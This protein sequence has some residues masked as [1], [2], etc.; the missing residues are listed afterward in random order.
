MVNFLE[1]LLALL[2][3]IGKNQF[4]AMYSVMYAL[5]DFKTLSMSWT[6]RLSR[7]FGSKAIFLVGVVASVYAVA[8]LVTNNL[9]PDAPKPCHDVILKSRF[10]SPKPSK[11]IVILDIDERSL[12]MLSA[13]YGR[14]PW[15]RSV[16][17]DG[18]QKVSDSGARAVMLNVMLSDPDKANA[19]ADAVMD[20]TAQMVRPVAFPLIRL[21]ASNDAVSQ[22]K[23]NQFSGSEVSSAAKPQ[24]TLAVI[25]PF[26]NSMHDRLGIANQKPDEDGIIRK[27][28]FVW[29]E[30]QFT[31]PS[32][33]KR[34]LE[35]GGAK[36]QGVPN[37]ISLN[38][39]NKQGRYY[40]MS[41]SDLLE[42]PADDP[43]LVVFK[44]SVVVLGLSAPGLGQTKATAVSSIEDDN[45]I[46][47][48]AVDDA[49]YG[50]YLRVMPDWVSLIINLLLIWA[51]VVFAVTKINSSF[52]DMGFLVAQ[53]GL[54]MITLLSASYTNYLIDL[55]DSM[56][57]GLGV[58]AAIKLVE[59]LNRSWTRAKPG[60]R[61][62]SRKNHF[63][64][65]VLI[66]YLET[67]ILDHPDLHK[68]IEKTVGMPRFICI[69]D[70]F[71]G[72][73][74]VS[75]PCA[76]CRILLIL[77]DETQQELLRNWVRLKGIDDNLVISHY[78]LKSPWDPD[79]SGFQNEVSPLILNVCAEVLGQ[80]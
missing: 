35:V 57:F 76:K 34:T 14:W 9:A 8:L 63:G 32:I 15:P 48:T 47:A 80:Q 3:R 67:M 27:Y 20:L 46:L 64:S 38:W 72:E 56:S 10:S 7:R 66:G 31:L 30:A 41:F 45:E 24:P 22:L 17:A 5:V 51:L 71:G 73:N 60:F 79:D 68:Y 36:Y 49:L 4:P 62:I 33:V 78:D 55:S 59:S 43:K 53:S 75:G 42:L 52:F 26:F 69:D 2:K 11:D 23:V 1:S 28:P 12:A 29:E 65:L 44:N 54:G 70:L 74:L 58:F 16:L 21:N 25:L 77:A 18:I 50:T 19:D 37:L 6:A 61:R 39:R 13:E 40:R